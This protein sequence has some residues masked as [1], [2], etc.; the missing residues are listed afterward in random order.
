MEYISFISVFNFFH[1]S[2]VDFRVESFTSL[3]E[4]I[5]KYFIVFNSIVNAIISFSEYPLL[6]YRS[7]TEFWCVNFNLTFTEF[8]Y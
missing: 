7:M 5:P 3:G 8:I 4:F 1:Q 6:V 2:F